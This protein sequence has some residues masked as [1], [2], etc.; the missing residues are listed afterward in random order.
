M[1]NDRQ[2][3][4]RLL[5]YVDKQE[6]SSS[7]TRPCNTVYQ[8][9]FAVLLVES[10]T[11]A[12]RTCHPRKCTTTRLQGMLDEEKMQPLLLVQNVK[13]NSRTG[14]SRPNMNPRKNDRIHFDVCTPF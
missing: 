3:W 4:T 1:I 5:E 11:F 8:T 12:P 6:E 14:G 2:L 13:V 10:G 9:F 7:F